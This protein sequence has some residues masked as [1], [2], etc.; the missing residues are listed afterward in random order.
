MS[1]T[2]IISRIPDPW[3]LLCLIGNIIH[4]NDIAIVF[5]FDADWSGIVQGELSSHFEVTKK[6][7][8]KDCAAASIKAKGQARM[9]SVRLDKTCII[10][11]KQVEYFT[12]EL[13][14]VWVF[15]IIASGVIVGGLLIAAIV[16][17]VVV[18]KRRKDRITF[19]A[20]TDETV[21]F[22]DKLHN[23]QLQEQISKQ[24]A[25]L[26]NA[27]F[28]LR[29]N[30]SFIFVKELVEIGS[31]KDV[32]YQVD[33]RSTW[34]TKY[35]RKGK[36][37]STNM[38]KR[39]GRQ[40]LEAILYLKDNGF[41]VHNNIH[42]GNVMVERG[43]CRLLGYQDF[44]LRRKARNHSLISQYAKNKSEIYDVLLFGHMLYEMIFGYELQTG[45][46]SVKDLQRCKN[47]EKS[48][49][50]EFT[51][52][53][54]SGNIPSF[55]KLVTHTFFADVELEELKQRYGQVD[56]KEDARMILNLVNRRRSSKGRAQP[57][58]HTTISNP[59]LSSLVE[60]DTISSMTSEVETVSQ[61]SQPEPAPD[62]RADLMASIAARVRSMA[63]SPSSPTASSPVSA[64]TPLNFSQPQETSSMVTTPIASPLLPTIPKLHKSTTPV[65]PPLPPQA[66]KAPKSTI[67]IAPPMP[68]P[69][70]KLPNVEY[71][72]TPRPKSA[73]KDTMALLKDIRKGSKL[74]KAVTNDRSAPKI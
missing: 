31:L 63:A 4:V 23:D 45:M 41:T 11:I 51:F 13:A 19:I 9:T 66:P 25:A 67:P 30:T 65:A 15:L 3:L 39:Y 7:A 20:S 12:M 36:K 40:I 8:A 68:P 1:S 26:L 28:Y 47:E 24:D 73:G 69:A 64:A 14:I 54:N 53:L 29:S 10:T 70:P 37:I 38:I 57:A 44:L 22:A 72:S 48:N 74:R 2:V 21:R 35:C 56:I 17:L 55:Q 43:N 6:E 52:G 33:P 32:I 50:L 18:C 61:R 71:K 58:V 27:Q 34:G 42:S 49:I 16:Y 62:P 46:P 60:D 5:A 59:G